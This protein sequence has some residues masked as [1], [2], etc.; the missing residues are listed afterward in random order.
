MKG[1]LTEQYQC[2][3]ANG[4]WR[5]QMQDEL[6]QCSMLGRR[7]R[8]LVPGKTGVIDRPTDV[9]GLVQVIPVV[10]IEHKVHRVS[11]AVPEFANQTDGLANWKRAGMYLVF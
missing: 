2:L 7:D 10:R 5:S 6:L 9:H 3:V 11:N 4:D 1:S 8:V